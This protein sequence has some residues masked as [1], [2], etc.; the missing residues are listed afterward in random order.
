MSESAA[1][2][3]IPPH[4]LYR[5]VDGEMVLL[6]LDREQYFGLDAIGADMVQRLTAMSVD[7][8]VEVLVAEYDVGPD[9]LRQDLDHLVASL[10]DAGLLAPVGAPG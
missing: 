3:Q 10:V 4:V 5:E 6:D 8:T 1:A 9:Q 2:F 7:E